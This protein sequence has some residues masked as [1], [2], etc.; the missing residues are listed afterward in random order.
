LDVKDISDG[1]HAIYIRAYDGEDYSQE[2]FVIIQI[3]K[4]GGGG[5]LS[6]EQD[7]LVLLLAAAVILIIVVIILLLLFTRRNRRSPQFIR[8]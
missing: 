3:D 2:K 6:E 4:G 7:M 1:E 8:L 5:L